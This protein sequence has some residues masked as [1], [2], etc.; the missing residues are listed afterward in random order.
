MNIQSDVGTSCIVLYCIALYCIALRCIVLHC[1]D[2]TALFCI[3][4]YCIVVQLTVPVTPQA[5][6]RVWK[7]ERHPML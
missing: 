7:N 6:Q 3:Q 2:C 4:L 5:N 1:V